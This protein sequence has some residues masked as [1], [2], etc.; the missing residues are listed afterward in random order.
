MR[1][2]LNV[3]FK[4]NKATTAWLS[5]GLSTKR[6]H[7][8]VAIRIIGVLKFFAHPFNSGTS[9]CESLQL[10]LEGDRHPYRRDQLALNCRRKTE[11]NRSLAP[12]SHCLTLSWMI[13]ARGR[14]KWLP[15]TLL[16]RL[17]SDVRETNSKALGS[18]S[19]DL[20][21]DCS[22]SFL[23]VRWLNIQD[24]RGQNRL[25]FV[26]LGVERVWKKVAAHTRVNWGITHFY[27]A[28]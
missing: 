6:D 21:I 15:F 9:N 20:T 16:E 19:L 1:L 17:C 13:L 26:P 14:D 25:N 3:I 28:L 8:I 10:V 22:R 5:E 4:L 7:V 23:F 24:K 2:K 11:V 18:N 12:L 27:E